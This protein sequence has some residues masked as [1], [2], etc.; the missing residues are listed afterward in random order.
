[1]P[2]S[3]STGKE[4]TFYPKQDPVCQLAAWF[5]AVPV[6]SLI[7]INSMRSTL[8]FIRKWRYTPLGPTQLTLIST[9]P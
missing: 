5:P 1:S 8:I 7:I 3:H 6:T 4:T 2:I 9:S